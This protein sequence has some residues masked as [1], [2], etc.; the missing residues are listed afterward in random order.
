MNL[1]LL[2]LFCWS[3]TCYVDGRR[4]VGRIMTFQSPRSL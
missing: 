1:L 2:S 4:P 3:R